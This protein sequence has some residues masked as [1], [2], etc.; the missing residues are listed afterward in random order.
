MIIDLKYWPE[1]MIVFL[2]LGIC[3][4]NDQCFAW[5]MTKINVI[6]EY[7]DIIHFKGKMKL[8]FVSKQ[9]SILMFY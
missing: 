3:L 7:Q 6:E 8:H 9:T 5:N 2:L 1:Q 4:A